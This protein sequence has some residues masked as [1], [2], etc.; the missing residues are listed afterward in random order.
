MIALTDV[1]FGAA[2]VVFLVALRRNSQ[3]IPLNA[4]VVLP[5]VDTNFHFVVVELLVDM[6]QV[7]L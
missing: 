5:Q 6:L 1:R 2:R 7:D 4:W 3:D